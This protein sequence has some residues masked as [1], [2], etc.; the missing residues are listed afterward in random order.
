M[1]RIDSV[2]KIVPEDFNTDDR[3]LVKKL[4]SVLNPFMDQI[5]A[6]LARRLTYRDNLMSETYDLTLAAGV[7]TVTVAWPYNDKP[8]AVYI[9]NLTKS[10]GLAPTAVFSLSSYHRDRKIDL[11]FLGLDVST[12]HRVTVIAQI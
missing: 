6:A 8:R 2:K 3:D 5:S 10:T 11:T 4:V 12:E 7:S 9:G 1:A